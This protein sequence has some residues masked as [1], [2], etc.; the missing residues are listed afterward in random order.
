MTHYCHKEQKKMTTSLNDPQTLW[1]SFGV[2]CQATI[3][4]PSGWGVA[5]LPSDC[6][7]EIT[8]SNF[9]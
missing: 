3:N 5:P 6:H 7:F 4:S 9:L 1:G 8:K 2:Y